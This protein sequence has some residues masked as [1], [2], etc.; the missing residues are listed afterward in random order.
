MLGGKQAQI[1]GRLANFFVIDAAAV[2]FYFDIYVIAA[3][4]G[5]HSNIAGI[6][7]ARS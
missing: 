6:A 1:H 2:V 5:T 7:L 4:V 3:M